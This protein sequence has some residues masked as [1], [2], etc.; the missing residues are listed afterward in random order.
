M[1]LAVLDVLR[2][3]AIAATQDRGA[4][5]RHRAIF[6]GLLAAVVGGGVL[7]WLFGGPFSLA[8]HVVE[9]EAIAAGSG[10]VGFRLGHARGRHERR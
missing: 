4:P 5:E 3:A 9:Y 6:P 10:W 7:V 8:F 1:R 2:G